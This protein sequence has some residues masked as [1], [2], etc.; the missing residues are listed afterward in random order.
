[1]ARPWYAE[2]VRFGCTR[3]GDCCHN[4]GEYDRVYFTKR[5]EV[6]VAQHLGITLR[7]LRQ[8]YIAREDGYRIARSR[9][10]ACVFLDG[11]R[12][13]IYPVR[14]VPCRTWPFWPETM[15][16]RDF[17]KDVEPFCKG[18]GRGRLRTREEIERAMAEKA[19]HNEALDDDT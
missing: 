19:R 15:S 4:H 3:G 2:G 16:R 11:C 13:S 8:R 18:V 14:P 17:A 5:E 1:M 12:C 10:E 6:K 7:A 9:G